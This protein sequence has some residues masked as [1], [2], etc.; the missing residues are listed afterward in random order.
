[1]PLIPALRRQRL[2][3]L[4]EFKASLVYIASPGQPEL[5]SETLSQTNKQTNKQKGSIYVK[6]GRL[7]RWTAQQRMCCFFTELEIKF[8]HP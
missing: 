7:E 8:Q 4:C 1:M 6:M 2:A 5:H 3:D